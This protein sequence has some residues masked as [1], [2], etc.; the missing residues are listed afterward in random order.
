MSGGTSDQWRPVGSRSA[1]TA[2]FCSVSKPKACINLTPPKSRPMV[3]LKASSRTGMRQ[4][5]GTDGDSTMRRR[6][7]PAAAH[8]PRTSWGALPRH[9]APNAAATG[10][11]GAA[12]NAVPPPA[13]TLAGSSCPA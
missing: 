11:A 8:A 1:S 10:D 6:Y 13:L 5:A 3:E 4:K 12:A 7:S 2:P 9:T